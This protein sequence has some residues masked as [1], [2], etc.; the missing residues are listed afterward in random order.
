M[1]GLKET[2][3]KEKLLEEQFFNMNMYLE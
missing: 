3:A 1:W 2:A